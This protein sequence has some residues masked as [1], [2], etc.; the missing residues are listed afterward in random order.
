MSPATNKELAA[1]M[2]QLAERLDLN[3]ADGRAGAG[4]LLR[5]IE[6]KAPGTLMRMRAMTDIRRAEQKAIAGHA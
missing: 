4:A 6:A 3:S 1:L 2:I 5:E